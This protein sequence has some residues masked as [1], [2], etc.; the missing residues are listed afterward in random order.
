MREYTLD[1]PCD[2]RKII[3]ALL[4]RIENHY[5]DDISIVACYGSYITGTSNPKSDLDFYFIPKTEKGYEMCNQFIIDGIGYDFWP[6]SWERAERIANFGEP[7]VSIIADAKIVY[8]CDDGDRKRYDMLK[9]RIKEMTDP[10]NKELLISKAEEIMT[11]VKALFFDACTKSGDYDT[12]R[13]NCSE[14]L[15]RLLT[16]AAYINSTYLKKGAANVENEVKAFSLVPDRFL[17]LFYLTAGSDR[18][19]YML[20]AVKKLIENAG[21]LIHS[22]KAKSNPDILSDTV[23]GFYE[24]LKSTYNKLIHACETKN[25][26]KAYFAVRS[27]DNET[28]GILGDRYRELDFPNLLVPI[29]RNNFEALKERAYLHEEKLVG[30]LRENG[31]NINSYKDIDDFTAVIEL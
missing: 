23:K 14:I 28:K 20:D 9:S 11:E 22:Q 15:A 25:L 1:L 17:E 27:I 19:Q 4:K 12:V 8:Y 7:I 31:V 3:D 29:D 10:V 6:V 21:S 16:A 26:I 30:I 2:K 18:P 24:E 5:R 13:A